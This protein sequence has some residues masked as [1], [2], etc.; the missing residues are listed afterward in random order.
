M[1]Q[2]FLTGRGT[3]FSGS[4]KALAFKLNGKPGYTHNLFLNHERRNQRYCDRF[5]VYSMIKL[6]RSVRYGFNAKYT[7]FKPHNPAH[8]SSENKY[9]QN[10]FLQFLEFLWRCDL[11]VRGISVYKFNIYVTPPQEYIPFLN[12]GS[13][14]APLLFLSF[15][16]DLPSVINVTMV[17]RCSH[18]AHEATFCRVPSTMF[19]IGQ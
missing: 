18:H 11:P 6:W 4:W 15:V 3:Q 10:G 2:S 19:G 14:I 12:Q 17:S 13:A 1:L 8:Q 7:R 16:S 5:I 9:E